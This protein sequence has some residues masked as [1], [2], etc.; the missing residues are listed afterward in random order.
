MLASG[1]EENRP[2]KINVFDEIGRLLMLISPDEH[3]VDQEA[4]EKYLSDWGILTGIH[5]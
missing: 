1:A 3:E 4:W 5:R 2:Y